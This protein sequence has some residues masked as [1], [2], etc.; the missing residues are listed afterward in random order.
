MPCR[1]F[2][3]M[4]VL[5]EARR[6]PLLAILC[7]LLTFWTQF[8]SPVLLLALSGNARPASQNPASSQE[9]GDDDDYALNLTAEDAP[10]RCSR[11]NARPP[12]RGLHQQG[13]VTEASHS[14]SCDRPSLPTTPACE[15]PCRNVIGAPLLC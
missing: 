5:R 14:P 7:A 15:H 13:A 11:R 9:D 6:R 8:D 12:L 4:A 10:I 1:A 3:L 2:P